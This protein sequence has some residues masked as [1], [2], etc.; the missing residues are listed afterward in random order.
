MGK[1]TFRGRRRAG[2]ALVALLAGVALS[3][4]ASP[5][6]ARA[7]TKT[8][9]I[10]IMSASYGTFLSIKRNREAPFDWSSDGCSWTP[11]P[12]SAEQN[13]PCQLHDFGYRNFGK[14]LRLERTESRRA[15]IDRRFLDEMSRNCREHWWYTSCPS[16]IYTMYGA[17]RVF[18]D[19]RG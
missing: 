4:V 8:R 2:A 13:G 1:S 17:V 7:T 15:W 3:T 6:V 18:N 9:A 16:N 10:Q 11:W 12:W 14:G 19:W 5:G